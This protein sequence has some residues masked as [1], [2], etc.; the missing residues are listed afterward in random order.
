MTPPTDVPTRWPSI[1][2][3]VSAL[4]VRPHLVDYAATCDAISWDE[5]RRSLAGLPGVPRLNIAYEAVDRHA[6]H[7]N[8]EERACG[9]CLGCGGIAGRSPA[10]FAKPRRVR[11]SGR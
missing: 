1:H 10:C 5:A 6:D 8:E 3:D 4:A 11:T 2:K 9:A 7:L